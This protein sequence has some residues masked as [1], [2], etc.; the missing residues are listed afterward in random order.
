MGVINPR[1]IGSRGPRQPIE[2]RF[3]SKVDRTSETGCWL[4]TAGKTSD[5]Y[6][7]FFTGTYTAEG[8]PR[9]QEA[10]RW[11][12]TRFV[13]E[14][15]EMHV[16]HTCNVRA[17]V[18]FS[19]HLY[20]GTVADNMRDGREAGTINPPDTRGF[21]RGQGWK[22]TAEQVR[23]IRSMDLTAYGSQSRLARELGVAPQTISKIVNGL[24]WPEV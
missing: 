1:N 10:H 15:G 14:P 6:G 24:S 16:C 9:S 13:G 23:I 21:A 4:W 2:D 12:Y 18:N 8:R 17:C 22:L 19:A 7:H 11:A 20:L 5:G 3:W